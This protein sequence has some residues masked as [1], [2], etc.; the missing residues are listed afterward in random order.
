MTS[1]QK[2]GLKP[3]PKNSEYAVFIYDIIK[4]SY[5]NNFYKSKIS[6]AKITSFPTLLYQAK[7]TRISRIST[8]EN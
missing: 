6:K 5:E 1:C 2:I 3:R 4:I 7:K 8:K